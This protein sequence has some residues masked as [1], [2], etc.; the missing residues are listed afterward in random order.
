MRI[1]RTTLVADADTLGASR[2]W[3]DHRTAAH[4]DTRLS[5]C[6]EKIE[7]QCVENL[8]RQRLFAWEPERNG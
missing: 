7:E 5:K 4:R 8:F 6:V 2:Q 3:L 1:P